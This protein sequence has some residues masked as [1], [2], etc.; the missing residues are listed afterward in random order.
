VLREVACQPFRRAVFLGSGPLSGVAKECHL[1]L[2]ELTDGMVICKNDSYLGF[3]HG[4]KAVVDEHTLM[5]YLSSNVPYV[6]R[7]ENDL[8]RSMAKGRPPMIEILVSE[9]ANPAF[10]GGYNLVFSEN[11][12]GG[13][14]EDFLCICSV[15]PGQLLGFY[16]SLEMGFSPDAPSK[17]G[18]ISR[19]VEGVSIYP[20][21]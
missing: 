4:P 20:V 18:A 7:Y 11:G 5:F 9:T 14:D 2:Q 19:V 13:L 12:K 8:L 15:L 6:Q 1:K 17:S 10:A 21:V 16:K 3:R